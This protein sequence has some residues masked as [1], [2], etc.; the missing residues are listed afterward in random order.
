MKTKTSTCG[1]T[2]IEL[3]AVVAIIIVLLSLLIPGLSRVKEKGLR[4]LCMSNMRQ[5]QLAHTRYSSDNNGNMP[6]ASTGSGG[7]KDWVNMS[8]TSFDNE[9]AVRN[10]SLWKYINDE[11]VYKCPLH[12]IQDFVVSYSVNNYLNGSEIN[13]GW[14]MT[15]DTVGQV[16][17][18]T[19]T[20][21]FLEEPDPRKTVRGSWVTYLS[22]AQMNQWVDPIGTWH[23]GGGAMFA[24]LDGH[25]EDW[26]WQDARTIAMGYSFFASTPGNPDLYRIKKHMV[27]G[28]TAYAA[29]NAAIP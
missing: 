1:F 10:G 7:A 18:P 21:S 5:L 15:A 25:T 4:T 6:G 14:T 19:K 13:W 3:L 16:P 26:M 29:F 8:G 9:L 24:F 2:L 27:P 12:P 20:I 28:E 11:K 23:T 17:R 22:V